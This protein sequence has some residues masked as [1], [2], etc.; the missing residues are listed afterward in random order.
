MTRGS[1]DRPTPWPGRR[2]L[3]A[4][5]GPTAAGTAKP[6]PAWAGPGGAAAGGLGFH[7]PELLPDVLQQ[8]CRDLPLA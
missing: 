1:S 5:P 6:G 2:T 8:R 4:L 3:R 7:T